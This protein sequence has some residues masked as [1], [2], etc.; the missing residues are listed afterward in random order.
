MLLHSPS[1]VHRAARYKAKLLPDN[2]A[3]AFAAAAMSRRLQ[4]MLAAAVPCACCACCGLSHL[5][6]E[7]SAR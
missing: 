3:A 4:T 7:R 2:A 1:Q 5:C 6:P